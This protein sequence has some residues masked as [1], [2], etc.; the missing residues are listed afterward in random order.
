[1]SQA[2]CRELAARAIATTEQDTT[3]RTNAR[4]VLK[5]IAA[6]ARER[7]IAQSPAAWNDAIKLLTGGPEKI[8]AWR[9]RCA[10]VEQILRH[11][12]A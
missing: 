9:A 5:E 3:E 6:E 10:E 8:E 12:G 1:M 7:G 4:T 11:T 2:D